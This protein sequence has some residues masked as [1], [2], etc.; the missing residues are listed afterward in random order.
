MSSSIEVTPAPLA[1]LLPWRELYRR[2]MSCQIVHDSWHARGFARSYLLSLG[3]EAVGYGSVGSPPGEEREAVKEFFV[4][5]SKDDAAERLFRR[6]LVETGAGWIEAQTN[7]RLLSRMLEACAV[8]PEVEAILFADGVRT[9]LLAP[10]GA[11]LR[12]LIDADR[13]TIFA[14]VV[15]PVGPWGLDLGGEIVATGGV[16]HHYNPPY[17]DV[18]MEVAP[19]HRRRGFGSY[20]VQELKRLCREGGGVPAARCGV[21]NEA[22]RR[23]LERAGMRVCGRIVRCQVVPALASIESSS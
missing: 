10:E 3:G 19:G 20:L 22:S 7:D 11:S 12:A 18:F 16:L 21:T 13:A 2:E 4:L 6:L 1:T 17:G 8:E 14:H 5:P 15:E 23:T 9:E